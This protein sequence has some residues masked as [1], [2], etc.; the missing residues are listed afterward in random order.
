MGEGKGI[1][2]IV[3][4]RQ[5]SYVA[6]DCTSESP[7][8]KIQLVLKIDGAGDS[9]PTSGKDGVNDRFGTDATWLQA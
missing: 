2:R 4:A 8:R 9:R 1:G 3:V 5:T 6:V 7:A